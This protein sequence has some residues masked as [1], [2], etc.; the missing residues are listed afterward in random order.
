MV[1]YSDGEELE[2]RKSS[3]KV[4]NGSPTDIED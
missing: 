3:I 4:I 2:V 1:K